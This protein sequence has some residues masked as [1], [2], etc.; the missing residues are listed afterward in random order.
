M[1]PRRFLFFCFFFENLLFL[2]QIQIPGEGNSI[3]AIV[4]AGPRKEGTLSIGS[5][6]QYGDLYGYVHNF[7]D[8]WESDIL[9]T[10]FTSSSTGG[11][12]LSAYSRWGKRAEMPEVLNRCSD[13]VALSNLTSSINGRIFGLLYTKGQLRL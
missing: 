4:V 10:G 1:L 2:T 7:C 5:L 12:G 3:Y 9:L 6:D 8:L 11:G 13:T